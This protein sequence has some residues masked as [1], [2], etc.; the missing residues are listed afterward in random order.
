MRSVI[1]SV[2]QIESP[3]PFGDARRGGIYAGQ[4]ELRED[5][6][7]WIKFG[8]LG[9]GIVSQPQIAIAVE[10]KGTA[11]AHQRYAG[12]PAKGKRDTA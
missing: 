4:I 10:G 5:A 11:W 9:I 3:W 7:R 1:D 2:N 6:R 8:E 12:G